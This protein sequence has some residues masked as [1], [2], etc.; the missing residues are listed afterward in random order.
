MAVGLEGTWFP[1]GREAGMAPGLWLPPQVLS[2]LQ[3]RG[4]FLAP[5]V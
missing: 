4:L 3:L 2:G 5:A 1:R